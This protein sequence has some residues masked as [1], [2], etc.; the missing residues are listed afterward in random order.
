MRRALLLLAL[1][2]L[3]SVPTATPEGRHAE[4]VT[5]PELPPVQW[6]A[7]VD[8]GYISTAPLVR[9]GLVVVK[10]GGDPIT[11]EGAGMAAFRADSG[12]A[13]W[14]TL[15]EE[16]EL[17][18]EVAPLYLRTG[19][20]SSS[21]PCRPTTPLIITGWSSG[22]LTAH[23]LGNGTEAWN[24]STPAPQ[25]GIN[26]GGFPFEGNIVWPTETGLVSVC[27]RNGTQLAS[28][29]DE[30]RRTYRASLGFDGVSTEVILGTETGH[31]LYFDDQLNLTRDLDLVAAANLSG[32]WRI[33]S[34][35]T[36]YTGGWLMAHLHGD[37][38]SVYAVFDLNWT[39]IQL[40]RTQVLPAGTSTRD[41]GFQ[42]HQAVG[43][44]EGVFQPAWKNDS[45]M[46]D[47]YHDA[48]KVVGELNLAY[49]DDERALCIPQNTP[50]GSW[51]MAFDANHSVEWVPDVGG[52]LTAG[53]GSD[54]RAIAAANDA[55]WLE[56]RYDADHTYDLYR[57]ANDILGIET[58]ITEITER[59]PPE[60]EDPFT[61]PSAQ[62][63]GDAQAVVWLPFWGAVLVFLLGVYS[64][65]KDLRRQ[66][67]AAAALLLLLALIFGA[68]VLNQA[69]VEIAPAVEQ[70][71]GRTQASELQNWEPEA[72]TVWVAFHFPEDV[73]PE[74]CDE[75]MWQWRRIGSTGTSH[76]YLNIETTE[77]SHCVYLMSI[78]IDEADTVEEV[79]IAA[80][81]I[82]WMSHLIEMQTMGP[83]LK[84]VGGAEGGDA[85][86]WWTY[87]LNGEYGQLGMADQV[88]VPGD[89]IDWHFDAG[90]F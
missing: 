16:S 59:E 22:I 65:R 40:N 82:P 36:S 34:V 30:N 35:P 31:L 55:S 5:D 73:A 6:N 38:E 26:A 51:L 24:I 49:W 2:L 33:R 61:E 10:G 15:H 68:T 45:I 11:G 69:V 13:V 9:E 62:S 56:V 28:D 19:S 89:E 3:C 17:G 90:Q 1:L 32:D 4:W 20:D 66:I 46:L 85:E 57:D 84:D 52:Y 63:T 64:P 88:V 54:F 70:D 18:F 83:F 44:N 77:G 86:R 79:T 74:D 12:E 21:L 14:R 81:E 80:L 29:F 23:H 41:A 72:D 50:H 42:W 58:E 60:G 75:Q 37:G 8:I 87:D 43:T 48:E 78:E 7:S 67:F 47:P 27:E 25:W 76:N 71:S 53:C 39:S